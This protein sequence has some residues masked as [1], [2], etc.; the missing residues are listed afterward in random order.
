[1]PE[2]VYYSEDGMH[3]S[4][5]SQPFGDGAILIPGGGNHKTGHG[6]DTL[7]QFKNIERYTRERFKV[8]SIDY[9]WSTQD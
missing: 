5:R 7:E 2:G 3:H 4:M 9:F 8:K 6:G 1:M